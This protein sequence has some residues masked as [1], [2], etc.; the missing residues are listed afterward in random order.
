MDKMGLVVIAGV[1]RQFGQAGVF[2]QLGHSKMEAFQLAVFFGRHAD[3]AFEQLLDAAARKGITIIEIGE[4][5]LAVV[6]IDK[7]DGIADH[8]VFGGGRLAQ[9][10]LSQGGDHPAGSGQVLDLPGQFVAGGTQDIA[11]EKFAI[12][13]FAGGD[14]EQII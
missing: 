12:G 10:V 13:Y 9:Q 14:M 4:V 11:E 3:R 1:Q 6:P 7:T 5:N 2:I 8:I